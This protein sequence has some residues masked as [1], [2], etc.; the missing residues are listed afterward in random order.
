MKDVKAS[1]AL[2]DPQDEDL[3]HTIR[4]NSNGG[5]AI[6]FNRCQNA[7]ETFIRNDP[8]YPCKVDDDEDEDEEK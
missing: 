4:A 3:Y 7:N 5:P 6:I 2:I 1:I 8:S